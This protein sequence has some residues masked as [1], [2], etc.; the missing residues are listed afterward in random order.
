MEGSRWGYVQR[1]LILFSL[2]WIAFGWFRVWRANP[3]KI[4]PREPHKRSVITAHESLSQTLRGA[5]FA[6]SI[7]ASRRSYRQWPNAAVLGY[8][9]LLG[10]IRL[11][12]N[13]GKRHSAAPSDKCCLDSHFDGDG[14]GRYI[15]AVGHRGDLP[16]RTYDVSEHY[17]IILR[18]LRC[19]PDA[20]RVDTSS[21]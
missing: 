17:F 21:P 3:A 7:V 6:S 13:G 2:L 18:S 9:F 8:V 12:A 14:S 4:E 15:S 16:N 1:A 11:F 20:S 10:V 19:C 5:A